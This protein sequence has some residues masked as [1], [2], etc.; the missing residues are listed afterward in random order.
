MRWLR[1]VEWLMPM[2][3][4]V[5]RRLIRGVRWVIPRARRAQPRVGPAVTVV[6]GGVC[7]CRPRRLLIAAEVAVR[8]RGVRV[9]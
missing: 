3:P 5:R 1:G 4:V 7:R 6:A 9:R 2:W 8:G